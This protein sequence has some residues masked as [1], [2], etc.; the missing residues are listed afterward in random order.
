MDKIGI[1]YAVLE[2]RN[3]MPTIE[4]AA[5]DNLISV[6]MQQEKEVTA[7]LLLNS[8]KRIDPTV[9]VSAYH[10]IWLEAW[11]DGANKERRNK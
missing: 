8:A 2:V 6:A 10:E 1:S 3:N 11:L 5:A 9:D 7:I 4:Q